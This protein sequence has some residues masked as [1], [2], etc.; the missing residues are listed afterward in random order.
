MQLNANM[1]SYSIRVMAV[2]MRKRPQQ[3]RSRQMVDTLIEATA[4][5]IAEHGLD[6]TTTPKIAELAGVSVGSLYQYF[7]G[8][9]ALISA[10]IEKMAQDIAQA[11]KQLPFSQTHD[12]EQMVSMAIRF[13][14]TLLDS[15][16]KLYL[17]LASNWQRLPTQRVADVLQQHFF[18]LARLYFLKHYQQYPIE[19]LH[20]KIF[21]ISNSTIFTMVRFISENNTMLQADEVAE[22]LI[23]MIT[24]YLKQS[25][26]Q[27]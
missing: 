24:G 4:R 17:E 9:D 26:G 16:N 27:V 2:D 11:L 21:I 12:L 8:K 18:E 3:Q 6:G 1:Y 10:L 25:M 13:G 14:F 7:D 23:Q 19:N 20:T 5:C 15:D 22:G